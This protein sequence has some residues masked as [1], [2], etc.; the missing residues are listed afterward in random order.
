M[1][2]KYN[3]FNFSTAMVFVGAFFCLML[4]YLATFMFYPAM[5][6]FAIGFGMLSAI[7]IKYRKKSIADLEQKQEVLVME[8][9]MNDDGEVFVMRDQAAD[10]RER[11]KRRR[12]K[13]QQLY[14]IIFSILASC[15]FVYFFIST[16][17]VRA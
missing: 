13:R 4:Y 8:R 1:K 5:L 15:L 9:T 6:L 3:V 14:P 2:F 7:L 16:L 17:I 11:K 10:K 12:Q